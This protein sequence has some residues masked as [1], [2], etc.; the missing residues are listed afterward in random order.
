MPDDFFVYYRLYD[1]RDWYWLADDGRLWSS[2]A[3][4][5]VLDTD[6]DYVTWSNHGP[7]TVWPRDDNG[8]QTDAALQAVFD[9]YDIVTGGIP[10]AQLAENDPSKFVVR[11]TK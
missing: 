2:K 11:S 4:A 5:L 3:K 6:P 10:A 1:Y 8:D 9:S 7:P